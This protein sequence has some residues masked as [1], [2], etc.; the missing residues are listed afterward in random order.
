MHNLQ[1][2]ITDTS[3]QEYKQYLSDKV[4][5]FFFYTGHP[6]G[7]HLLLQHFKGT[8]AGHQHHNHTEHR[9][10]H[11]DDQLHC[12]TGRRHSVS[13]HYLSGE[14]IK[15]GV[16]SRRCRWSC[17]QIRLRQVLRDFTF[18]RFGSAGQNLLCDQRRHVDFCENECK[19]YRMEIGSSL[20]VRQQKFSWC[21]FGSS[22]PIPSLSHTLAWMFSDI[23]TAQ[24]LDVQADCPV[25]LQRDDTDIT[26]SKRGTESVACLVQPVHVAFKYLPGKY[27]S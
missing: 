16:R 4:C 25:P 19:D 17:T 15:Y 26:C 12:E 11:D 23:R 2:L 13:K 10:C 14:C 27:Q 7:V 18:V 5:C 3:K 24:E 8:D 9:G 22:H 6:H 20:L 21:L 1:P